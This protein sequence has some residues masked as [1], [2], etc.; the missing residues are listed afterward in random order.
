M[1]SF[2][3]IFD[4]IHSTVNLSK[5]KVWFV[6]NPISGT[7]PKHTVPAII[8][9]QLDSKIFD[10]E[11]KYTTFKGHGSEIG[12]EAV[13]NK[14]DIVCAV[15]GDGSV[16]DIG[17]TLIGTNTKL[18]IL[19]LG[20]GNGLA[21]HLK[22]PLNIHDAIR[23]INKNNSIL[24]DTVKMNDA[25][26]LGFGGFGFDALIAKRFNEDNKRGFWVYVKHVL[27]EFFKF[28]TI[29]FT[30]ETNG[31]IKKIPGLMCTV[32]NTSEFG[33]GFIVSPK[34]DP[35]DGKLEL[36]I[37]KPFSF[38]KIPFVMKNYFKGKLQREAVSEV[39]SFETATIEMNNS[40]GHYDGEP[41]VVSNKVI[42]EVV[43]KSLHI[44]IGK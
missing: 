10:F 18:A 26:L 14:I 39:I 36:V 35:T 19:P 13:R 28:H 31:E 44:I 2:I 32:A 34:S 25:P 37:L 17:T 29:N 30:I 20:S 21:R 33:N 9:S 12:K 24:I 4:N 40:L 5:K 16:H 15:G 1:S 41:T 43:P 42:I 27:K 3:S 11:I 8:S 7:S 38:W 23:C 22:I 6:I